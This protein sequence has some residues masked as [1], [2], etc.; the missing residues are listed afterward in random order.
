MRSLYN[1]CLFYCYR[2]PSITICSIVILVF[3]IVILLVLF[4]VKFNFCY[5]F[6]GLVLKD[7]DDFYVSTLVSDSD[8]KKIPDYSFLVDKKKV[9]YQIINISDEYVLT[10]GG[11]KR[12]LSLK[13]DIIDDKKIVNNVLELIFIDN[14]TFFEKL[15]ERFK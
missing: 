14:K 15:K 13:F 10:D 2:D 6:N 1:K 7:G 11:L 3:L 8:I 9:N 5:R 12:E 4:F